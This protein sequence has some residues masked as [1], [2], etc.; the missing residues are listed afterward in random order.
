LAFAKYGALGVT[1][2]DLDLD[3]AQKVAEECK[4]TST[5]PN[6]RIEA[7]HI[8]VTSDVSINKAISSTIEIF[9]RIDYCVN[10]AGVSCLTP[11]FLFLVPVKD[12]IAMLNLIIIL[13]LGVKS[14]LEISDADIGEFERMLTT[15]VTGTFLVTKLVSAVMRSQEPHLNDLA[16]PERGLTRG[17]IVN[18]GSA[19]SFA[20]SPGMVQYTTSKFGVLGLTKNSGNNPRIEIMQSLTCYF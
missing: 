10:S 11:Y 19:S 13:K 3:A 18:L 14:N 17:T 16:A 20:S 6:F 5:N 7:L 8:D 2:A 1:V 4:T 12:F 15:N 9:G